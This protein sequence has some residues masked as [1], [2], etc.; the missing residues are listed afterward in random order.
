MEVVSFQVTYS[1]RIMN[2]LIHMIRWNS[3]TPMG[4]HIYSTACHVHETI[5]QTI[6]RH[7]YIPL[8][9]YT[10]LMRKSYSY[11]I[12]EC[13]SHD[14]SE[15]SALSASYELTEKLPLKV[16]IYSWINKQKH[17][18]VAAKDVRALNQLGSLGG[19]VATNERR[20]TRRWF[21]ARSSSEPPVHRPYDAGRHDF[22][23]WRISDVRRKFELQWRNDL[24]NRWCVQNEPWP[25]VFRCI[26][27][28]CMH[29]CTKSCATRK[30]HFGS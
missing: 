7:P 12:L 22:F 9:C 18:A 8:I 5:K 3:S 11:P 2:F 4:E 17:R 30:I 28:A 23:F 15:M 14:A 20:P 24:C 27:P 19:E 29:V 6:H 13:P 10:R 25:T 26:V 16:F 1:S 21:A